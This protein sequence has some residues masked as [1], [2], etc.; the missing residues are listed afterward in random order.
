MHLRGLHYSSEWRIAASGQHYSTHRIFI[1]TDYATHPN[2]VLL[3]LDDISSLSRDFIRLDYAIP[4][5][6]VVLL[7]RYTT[8][9]NRV[10]ICT[11]YS[12]GKG[13]VADLEGCSNRVNNAI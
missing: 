6:R 12:I 9:P 5:N 8:P 3:L 1:L 2:G 10:S 13:N 7:V 4:S 11:E